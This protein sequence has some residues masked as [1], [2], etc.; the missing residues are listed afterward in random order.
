[1]T[2]GRVARSSWWV[3]RRPQPGLAQAALGRGGQH[4]QVAVV[5]GRRPLATNVH[6]PAKAARRGSQVGGV[7]GHHQCSSRAPGGAERLDAPGKPGNGPVAVGGHGRRRPHGL[8]CH[9]HNATRRPGRPDPASRGRRRSAGRVRTSSGQSTS[10]NPPPGEGSTRPTPV[11]AAP[12]T[13]RPCPASGTCR[14]PGSGRR[15]SA[16]TGWPWRSRRA[17]RGRRPRSAPHQDERHRHRP[18]Y[19]LGRG[20]RGLP[21]NGAEDDD[22]ECGGASSDAPH[23]D[24]QRSERPASGSAPSPGRP[25]GRRGR[26]APWVP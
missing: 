25:A 4:A 7:G 6:E 8:P 5:V 13:G 15:P 26:M 17:Q 24:G 22:Q 19:L 1:M 10:R 23:P 11:L 18:P 21:G 16:S 9:Q 14:P 12:P 20:R 3:D 2:S